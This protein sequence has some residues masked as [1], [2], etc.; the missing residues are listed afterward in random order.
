MT[1]DIDAWVR[2]VQDSKKYRAAGISEMTIRAILENELAHHRSAKEAERAARKKLHEVVAPY[3]GD[4]AYAD[5]LHTL[6][7]A[8]NTRD[9]SIIRAALRELMAAH[10]STAERL[11]LLDTFYPRIFAITGYPARILDL[12]CALNPLAYPWMNAPG[13]EILAYDIHQQ[14]LD[15]LRAFFHLAGIPGQAI[16]QDILVEYPQPRAPVALLL[17]EAARMEKRQRGTVAPLLAALDVE[18]IVLSLPAHSRTGRRDLS[19]NYQKLVD[20]LLAG[21][22][23]PVTPLEFANETVYCIHKA[24]A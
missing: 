10:H 7:R 1:L 5:A 24:H 20:R 16:N 12:A 14:R 11:P 18:W 4:P 17:K 19:E 13:M 2:Q 22:D 9:D 15:F 21:Q 23:W 3:L 6:Q 8:Y